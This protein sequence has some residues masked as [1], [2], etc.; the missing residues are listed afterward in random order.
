MC[1][2]C[3][4]VFRHVRDTTSHVQARPDSPRRAQTRPDKP[5][6]SQM[7]PAASGACLGGSGAC[8]GRVWCVSCACL[9]V[10]RRVWD[11]TSHAQACPDSPRCAQTRPDPPRHAQGRPDAS[12]QDKTHPDVGPEQELPERG[13]GLERGHREEARRFRAELLERGG[14]PQRRPRSGGSKLPSGAV[15]RSLGCL[16]GWS[17]GCLNGGSLRL[18]FCWEGA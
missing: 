5:R 17:L 10:F 8:V 4:G 16:K 11:T 18:M 2:A 13:G 3:L 1:G 12:R 15:G 6:R 9:G 14:G 7:R